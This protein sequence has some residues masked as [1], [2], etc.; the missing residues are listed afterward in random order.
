MHAGSA[1]SALLLVLLSGL[2]WRQSHVYQGQR[3]AVAGYDRQEP[4]LVDA[5]QQPRRRSLLRRGAAEEAIREFAAAARLS[6]ESWT[7]RKNLGDAYPAGGPAREAIREYA[8]ALKLNPEIIDAHLDLANLLRRRLDRRGRRALRGGDAPRSA[9]TQRFLTISAIRSSSPAASPGDRR[10]SSRRSAWIRAYRR[11][12]PIWEALWRAW[13]EP[14]R[15]STSTNEALRRNPDAAE[16]HNNLGARWRDGARTDSRRSKQYREALRLKP[17]Y[18][19]AANNLG[20]ACSRASTGI[21]EAIESYREALRLEPDFAETHNNP[22][23]VLANSKQLE[24]AIEHFEQAVTIRPD[25]SEARA[26][27]A[28]VR[29]MS[30]GARSRADDPR[31]RGVMLAGLDRAPRLGEDVLPFR[32]GRGRVR[33]ES[34]RLEEPLRGFLQP[35]LLQREQPQVLERACWSEGH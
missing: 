1:A 31:Q 11:P 17:D 19:E 34:N 35:P 32:L 25:F 9:E 23:S 21:P 15:R 13:A 14:A 5:A 28:A 2:T 26:N 33:M 22:G 20:A 27:L 29:R 8:A 30:P 7:P 12:R 3:D 16:I 24:E 18:A 4:G 6:P 10:G